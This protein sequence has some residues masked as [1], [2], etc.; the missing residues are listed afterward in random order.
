L[1][2]LLYTWRQMNSMKV[3]NHSLSWV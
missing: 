1:P 2:M 3:F